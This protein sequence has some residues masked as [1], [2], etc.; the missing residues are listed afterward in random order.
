MDNT[1]SQVQKFKMQDI[2]QYLTTVRSAKTGLELTEATK[3][4]QYSILSD[5]YNTV[6]IYDIK[7]D[8]EKIMTRLNMGKSQNTAK[9]RNSVVKTF[10][11][12][13]NNQSASIAQNFSSANKTFDESRN[14]FKTTLLK[15][16]NKL[17]QEQK[18]NNV[19]K[20]ISFFIREGKQLH[21]LFGYM[22]EKELLE[23]IPERFNKKPQDYE[24]VKDLV[25]QFFPNPSKKTFLEIPQK[26]KFL[27]FIQANHKTTTMTRSEI[28]TKYPNIDMAMIE[29]Q[30]AIPQDDPK[31]EWIGSERNWITV[32]ML[33]NEN[34]FITGSAGLGKSSMLKQFCYEE[35]IPYVRTSCNYSADPQDNYFEQTFN[36]TK[37]EY[38]AISMG[39]S[40]I[41]ANMIGACLNSQEEINS[42]NE[43]TMIGMHSATDSIKSLNTKMGELALFNKS[44]LLIAGSGNVGYGQGELTPALQSRLIPFTKQIPTDKFILEKIWI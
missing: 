19:D 5:L 4:S 24:F 13:M 40:F 3:Q 32:A 33:M 30:R 36:G 9:N 1:K 11:L 27:E 18:M 28:A 39:L 43:A 22:S 20:I 15:F 25:S 34:L 35:K 16:V 14:E 23:T 29:P 17:R 26:G 2:S 7:E 31:Y 44:K 8:Y 21:D 37:V 12:Y 10:L 38:I 41:Y 6:V 42:S